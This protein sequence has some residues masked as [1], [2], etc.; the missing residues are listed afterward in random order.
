MSRIARIV[1]VVVGV[2]VLVVG[3]VFAGQGLNLIPGSSMT[4]DRMWFYIGAIMVIVGI[5]LIVLGARR[6]ADS[7]GRR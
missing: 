1:L 7:R 6:S 5:I 2:V 3:A 4:G